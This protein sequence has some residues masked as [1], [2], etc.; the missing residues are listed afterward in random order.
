MSR[1]V[2]QSHRS[3][4]P[5]PWIDSC[6]SSVRQWAESHQYDYRY[7]GDELFDLIPDELVKQHQQHRV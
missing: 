5:Y 7:L 1:L 2:L 4:L 6:L 3:P